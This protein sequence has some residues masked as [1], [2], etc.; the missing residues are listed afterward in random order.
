MADGNANAARLREVWGK[1]DACKGT[2]LVFW[3]D[4]VTDDITVY[5]LAD[6]VK[7]LPFT[8]QRRGIEEFRQY[9]A[10]LTEMMSMDYW[11]IDDTISEGD[12]VVGIGS[13]GWTHRATGK[14]F[15][16]PVVFVTRW[17]D[18]RICAYAEY[19]DTY[20]VAGCAV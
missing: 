19:Y 5:S 14:S 6:G 11:R 9:L 2:D 4:H 16:T 18:G 17:R 8:A 12:R 20:A 13:T 15:E 1:W 7:P 3:E 10:G